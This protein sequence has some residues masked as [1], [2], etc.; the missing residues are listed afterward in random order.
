MNIYIY[1]HIYS[2]LPIACR[3]LTQN[4]KWMDGWTVIDIVA[5]GI[6][7]KCNIVSPVQNT[8]VSTSRHLDNMII[9]NIDA[10]QNRTPNYVADFVRPFVISWYF[11]F[12]HALKRQG[13]L[14][15]A[16][17]LV[18]SEMHWK[19]H[20]PTSTNQTPTIMMD[21]IVSTRPIFTCSSW[22]K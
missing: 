8:H 9:T 18:L 19:C 16:G 22:R 2:C 13:T 4:W 12:I 3:F 14:G 5:C 11:P 17:N 6:K 20:M 21:R 15:A 1:V 7:Q 10:W